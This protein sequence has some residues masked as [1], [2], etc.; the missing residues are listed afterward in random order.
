MME[1][2]MD[3]VSPAAHRRLAVEIGSGR[4]IINGRMSKASQAAEAGEA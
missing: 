2:D 4:G 3:C 1:A